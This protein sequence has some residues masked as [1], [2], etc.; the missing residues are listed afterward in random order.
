MREVLFYESD[1]GDFPAREFLDGLDTKA[2]LKVNFAIGLLSSQLIVPSKFWKK[3]SGQENLWELRA[4]YAGNIYRVLACLLKGNRVLLLHGFQK[5]SQKTPDRKSRLPS[6][7]R[8]GIFS[9]TVIY[10]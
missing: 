1:F 6:S 7:A 9:D 4:E 2:R 10:E 5:K 8:S 3:L